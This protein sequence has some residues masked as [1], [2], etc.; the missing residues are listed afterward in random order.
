MKI[1]L[2]LLFLSDFWLSIVNLKKRKSLKK[3]LNKESML[4]VRHPKKWLNF[5]MPKDEKKEIET[6]FTE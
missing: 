4:V 5:C 3:E 1:I 2:M 6:I